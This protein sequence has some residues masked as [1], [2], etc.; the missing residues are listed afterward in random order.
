[1][2]NLDPRAI[3][4]ALGGTVAGRNRVSA[5]G[6]GHSRHDRSLAVLIDPNAPG[7]LIVHSFA[8]DDAL[9]CKD[10]V[11]QRLGYGR[12]QPSRQSQPKRPA[13]NPR[14]ADSSNSGASA[15]YLWAKS[16]PIIGTPAE[17][18]LR[19]CRGILGPIPPTLR[20]LPA[21]EKYPPAMIAA[22]AMA[23][24]IEPGVLSVQPGAVRA[25]H[26]T[27][28]KADGSGKAD[29]PKPKIM[30]GQGA[31]GVPIIL[32]P[33]N[34]LLGLAITEGIEDALSVQA[35]TGLGAWA[36]GAASRMPALAEAVP[37]YINCVTIYGDDNKAGIDGARALLRSLNDRGIFAQIKYFNPGMG[38]SNG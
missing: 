13:P 28:L 20:Y 29:V 11:R 38:Q 33:P 37:N 16:K 4:H 7:G 23:E 19:V 14:E 18:Y 31:A 30:F 6:P 25:V 21:T 9:A 27:K 26:L 15:K 3:A 12:W 1:M 35:A 2:S 17:A 32:A 8:G 10:Y 24:E 5:P 36:A 22:F 34:D